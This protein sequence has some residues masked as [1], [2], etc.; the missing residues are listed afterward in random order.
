MPVA[1]ILAWHVIGIAKPIML[2]MKNSVVLF[3]LFFVVNIHLAVSQ[4]VEKVAPGIW[5]IV[6]GAPEKYRP[7]DFKEAPLAEALTKLPVVD[8]P[9][10]NLKG[11]QFRKAAGGIVAELTVD[12]AERFYGFGLQTNTFEQR[13]MRREIRTSSWVSGN[14][15][16]GHASMPF[17]ISSKGYG[18]SFLALLKNTVPPILKKRLYLKH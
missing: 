2:F 18:R 5:K 11:I 17:Y 16:F 8:S 14:L 15:G 4:T 7:A 12:T 1:F 10:F 3:F 13:G 6:F 9:P